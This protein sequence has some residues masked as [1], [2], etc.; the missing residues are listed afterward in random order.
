MLAVPSLT[1]LPLE[2][3]SP[4]LFAQNL[5]EIIGEFTHLNEA[6][7]KNYFFVQFLLSRFIK[8][9]GGDEKKKN[10]RGDQ[11]MHNHLEIAAQAGDSS[12]NALRETQRVDYLA[13]SVSRFSGIP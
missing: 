3:D 11:I 10:T 12:H 4:V 2:R 6:K 9:N 5:K 1:K 8:N 13:N 7:P